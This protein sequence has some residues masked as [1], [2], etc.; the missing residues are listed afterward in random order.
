MCGPSGAAKNIN[1]QIQSFSANVQQQAGQIFGDASSVFDNLKTS[2][3]KTIRG[4][5]SQQGWSQSQTNAVNSQII[6][7]AAVNNRNIK[8]S[9]NSA[10]AAAGGG[11]SVS[12][13]GLEATVNMQTAAATEEAKSQQL[14]QATVQNYETGNNNYFKA[15]SD[16]AQL[17]NV[18]NTSNQANE[19]ASKALDQAQ[20]SQSGIDSAKGWWKPLVMGGISSLAGIATGGLSTLATGGGFSKGA[21]S[22]LKG[23]SGNLMS[24]GQGS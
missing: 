19:V 8:S 21:G 1:N 4:G 12:P 11:N 23:L 16:E 10:L 6:D 14:E 15:V 17:P 18:F 20:T 9:V 22:A 2:L 24:Q 7:Q 5:P 3:D 13:S